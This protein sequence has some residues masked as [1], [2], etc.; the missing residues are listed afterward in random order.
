VLASARFAT[1]AARIAHRKG[2]GYP[3]GADHAGKASR[4]A[5]LP[6]GAAFRSSTLIQNLSF[7]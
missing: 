6:N 7:Q 2:I 3:A 5:V 1:A 4:G